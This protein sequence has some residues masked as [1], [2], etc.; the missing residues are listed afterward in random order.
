VSTQPQQIDPAFKPDFTRLYGINHDDK[1]AA[2]VRIP[3]TVK[4]SI[5]QIA[6]KDIHAYI[7]PKAD[8]KLRWEVVVGKNVSSFATKEEARRFYRQQRANAPDKNFPSKLPY[9]TFSK[10]GPDGGLEPDWDAIELHGPTP[11]ELDIVFTADDGY[12]AAYEFWKSSG[13]QCRGNGIDALRLLSMARPEEKA[14]AKQ[15][16]DAGDK[17]FPIIDGCWTRGCPYARPEVKGSKEYRQCAPHARLSFQLLNDIRLGGK[18]AFDTTGIK[19]TAQLFSS[20]MELLT[21]TGNGKPEHGF[22]KGIPLRL[23]M[24]PFKT[25]HNGQPGKAYAV[26]LEFR[27]E[28]VVG[29]RQKMLSFASEFGQTFGADVPAAR[30]IEAPTQAPTLE[31][32]IEDATDVDAA[33]MTNE[34]NLGGPAD[35]GPAD[36]DIADLEE[37]LGDPADEPTPAPSQQ[38]ATATG[39]KTEELKE[40]LRATRK[41]VEAQVVQSAPAATA[42]PPVKDFF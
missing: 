1:G 26:S 37:D 30:Q 34:F 20:I 35:D 13:L 32:E 31:A 2:L 12:Q 42:A 16:Q 41:P 33:M 14:L 28:S 22:L 36:G 11:I 6:G 5:G 4:V 18:A 21:F 25:N 38:A 3:R 27:A 10:V 8:A 9:F 19:S 17:N 39:A 7:T 40:K 23:L 24:R 29:M 15:C